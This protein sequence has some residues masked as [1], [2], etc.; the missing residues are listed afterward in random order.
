MRRTECTETEMERLKEKEMKRRK[1]IIMRHNEL[2]SRR[3]NFP[4][5]ATVL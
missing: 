5:H 1:E 3:G 4:Q 2:E